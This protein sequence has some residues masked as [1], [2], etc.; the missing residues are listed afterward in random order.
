MATMNK[1]SNGPNA[2]LGASVRR[3][4]WTRST[5]K[6]FWDI[7]AH[8]EAAQASYFASRMGKDVV[9]FAGYVTPLKGRRVLDFGCG[10]GHLIEHLLN[11]GALVAGLE[12]SQASRDVTNRK[13][14]ASKG[15]LGCGLV[16][17][18]FSP[19]EGSEQFDLVF[20]LE[21]IEHALE[22]DLPG[23][24]SGIRNRLRL[25]GH[26][27]VTTPNDENL[28]AE[29]VGCPECGAVFHRWQHV[30]RWSSVALKSSLEQ[31]GF[32]VPFC[33]GM[34]FGLFDKVRRPRI[35]D[36]S[37]RSGSSYLG[38][39]IVEILD[40]LSPRVFPGGRLLQRKLARCYT[41][42]L[43]AVVRRV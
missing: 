8:N 23:I 3:V 43:V 41:Q 14:S 39:K 17:E 28:E 1:Q 11:T 4:K 13:F 38:D 35:S 6:T 18:P 24:F 9:N 16:D 2:S 34:S 42:N 15:W 30:R 40:R 5:L 26:A 31:A 25:G 27:I 20:C 19:N 7:Q 12:Y 22:E 29:M 37:L 33:R 32:E 21:T 36:I 10:A